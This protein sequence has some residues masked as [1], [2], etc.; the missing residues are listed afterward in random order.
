MVSYLNRDRQVLADG[1]LNLC[2]GEAKD[3]DQPRGSENIVFINI[4]EHGPFTEQIL[5]RKLQKG[6]GR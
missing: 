2:D 3:A 4:K 5:Q 6:S 1:Y